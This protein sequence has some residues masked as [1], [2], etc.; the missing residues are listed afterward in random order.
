MLDILKA[1]VKYVFY[2]NEICSQDILN[3]FLNL[4]TYPVVMV[5]TSEYPNSHGFL[6]AKWL[7]VLVCMGSCCFCKINC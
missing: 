5:S 4:L 1:Q 7:D 3:W 2:S 6:I